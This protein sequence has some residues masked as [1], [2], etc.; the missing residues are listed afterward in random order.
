MLGLH[1][2]DLAYPQFIEMSSKA[3]FNGGDVINSLPNVNLTLERTARGAGG[4]L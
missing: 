1:S 3:F 4:K 2:S